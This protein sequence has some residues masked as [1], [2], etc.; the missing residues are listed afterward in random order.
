[1][2]A[3]KL[4]KY[5]WP[6]NF[7]SVINEPVNIT[8]NPKIL[9]LIPSKDRNDLLFQC[10]DSIKIHTTSKLTHVTVV[11]IDTGSNKDNLT[12][13]YEYKKNNTSHIKL[14]IKEH[15]YYNFAKNNNQAFTEM[16]GSEFDYVVFCNNDIKFL[17]DVLAHMINTYE[18]KLNVGSVGARLHFAD[19]K[20]QH[21]GAFC[22]MINNKAHPGHYGFGQ[23]ITGA[24]LSGPQAVAANTCALLMM[25]AK[26]FA[27]I[28]FNE[29]YLE[30]FEDVE[31]NLTLGIKKR[32][33]YC[34]L[35]ATAFHYESQTRNID[36]KKEQKQQSDLIKLTKFVIVNNH[37]KFIK[38]VCY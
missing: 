19:G 10:I 3:T 34:N 25:K 5:A 33:N 8:T 31:L 26:D 23:A 24:I 30:C 7:F 12:Q 6:E 37:H 22:K 16:K 15:G 2:Q 20:I 29:T 35:S 32:I 17:N 28:K 18:T 27:D 9:I 14:V 36:P 21:I 4:N 38:N 1:M 11:A 13:L